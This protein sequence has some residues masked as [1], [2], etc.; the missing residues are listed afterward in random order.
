MKKYQL[1]FWMEEITGWKNRKFKKTVKT[2]SL[3]EARKLAEKT[4]EETEKEYIFCD[5][6]V[7]E[8]RPL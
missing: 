3:E 5:I 8:V 2:S 4:K 1:T 6:G 7:S